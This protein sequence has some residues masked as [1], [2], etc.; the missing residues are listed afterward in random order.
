MGTTSDC[1]SAA[2]VVA[3]L[4]SDGGAKALSLS[5]EL[6]G[7]SVKNV[8]VGIGRA[9]WSRVEKILSAMAWINV[10]A[11]D[12]NGAIVGMATKEVKELETLGLGT[13]SATSSEVERLLALVIKAQDMALA[14][15]DGNLEIALKAN[16]QLIET[17]VDRL[18]QLEK[19]F[20]R[21]IDLAQKYALQAAK[22]KF[23]GEEGEDD[24]SEI[25]QQLVQMWMMQN[26]GMIPGLQPPSGQPPQAPSPPTPPNGTPEG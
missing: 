14:R 2:D 26:A 1:R 20:G 19:G 16:T 25:I 24:G 3:K 4:K 21:N 12:K 9:R 15:R 18:A 8:Q 6:V 22:A 23:S 7:G 17:L 5:V 10:E 13:S 11:L